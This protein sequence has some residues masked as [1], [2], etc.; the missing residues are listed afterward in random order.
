MH[1][2]AKA[3]RRWTAR[4]NV[5]LRYK[6]L[7][8]DGAE[9]AAAILVRVRPGEGRPIFLLPGLS[10]TVTEQH[11]LLRELRTQCPVYALQAPGVDGT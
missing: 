5:A 7:R 2:G 8:S 4:L 6:I 3:S 11:E 1:V 10:G 9:A